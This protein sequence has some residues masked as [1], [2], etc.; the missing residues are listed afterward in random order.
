MAVLK[1]SD[2][3]TAQHPRWTCSFKVHVLDGVEWKETDNI[4]DV[5]LFV[6]VNSSMCMSM[7]EH[8]ELTAS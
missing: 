4:G 3:T 8:P 1:D 6:K 5:A 7:R 2:Q